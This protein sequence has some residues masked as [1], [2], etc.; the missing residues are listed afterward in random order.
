MSCN[1]VRC[2]RC[3]TSVAKEKI[4]GG[5]S[6]TVDVVGSSLSSQIVRILRS[7][8]TSCERESC[9]GKGQLGVE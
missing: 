3:F 1:H 8:I 2:E 6:A 9:A 4:N 5:I 7:M